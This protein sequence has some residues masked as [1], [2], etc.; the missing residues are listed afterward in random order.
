MLAARSERLRG[1]V[2]RRATR[3][4][5]LAACA[6]LVA[7]HAADRVTYGLCYAA[8]HEPV[9]SAAE[10]Y[11]VY[12]R[13]RLLSFARML[14]IEAPRT[15]DGAPSLRAS[16]SDEDAALAYPLHPLRRADG[17]PQ[18]DILWLVAESLRSDMLDAEVMPRTLEFARGGRRF[19][20]HYS[21]GNGTR[22]A[23]FGMFYGLYGANWFPFLHASR[24]PVL[25]DALLDAGYEFDVRTS[26]R[27][28]FPEFDRTIWRR[29]PA[30]RMH[31]GDPGLAGWQNDRRHVDALT[32]ALR[33]PAGPRP[34]FRFLF[35]ESPH[36]PYRYP[37]DAE[38]RPDAAKRVNYVTMDTSDP[39]EVA[40]VRNRYVNAC[41]HLDMQLG[42]IYDALAE[43]GRLGRTLVIVTG[44]HGEEF[45]ERG[46]WGHHSGF[47]DQQ[48]RTPLVIRGPGIAPGEEAS[49]TSHLDLPATVLARI[50]VTNPPRDY[51]L[52]F[53]VLGG[54]R[55]APAVAAG[56]DDLCLIDDGAKIVLPFRG[57]DRRADAITR[58]D[59]EPMTAAES[60]AARNA[61]TPAIVSILRDLT[62]FTR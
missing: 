17:A 61:R 58:G 22:M 38:I 50:G 59:D 23:L 10:A 45:M 33:A 15:E 2:A 8:G 37:A 16:G 52:G 7:A 27:F 55:D 1:A 36:A 12:F 29:V 28:S 39:A 25:V 60:R 40:A 41:H 19:L 18:P 5:V 35:F 13:S 24:G 44:D 42:R 11:P 4:R 9:L 43:S 62:R 56:W 20:R 48:T 32:A 6:V 21:S 47:C 14:G 3:R 49:I 54:R 30:S 26:A 46:R 53:D 34:E 31:E 57:G 51:S